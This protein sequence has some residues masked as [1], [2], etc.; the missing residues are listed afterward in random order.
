MDAMVSQLEKQEKT[1]ITRAPQSFVA[2]ANEFLRADFEQ[3]VVLK[4]RSFLCTTAREYV[5]VWNAA[6]RDDKG[7]E[8]LVST[9][10]SLVRTAPVAES[11]KPTT[12]GT[13]STQ[14]ASEVQEGPTSGQKRVQVASG[15]TAGLLIKKVAPVY[16]QE[17]RMAYIQ[18]TVVMQADISREGDIVNLEVTDGPIELAGSAVHAVRHW[19]YKP[20]MLNGEAVAVRTTIQVN[21]ALSRN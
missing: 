17:A 8:T 6:A 1:R 3:K 18:G 15:M 7:V 19:K 5:L 2:G 21:Y 16:P 13:V 14:P 10:N 12:P 9:L 4:H 11:A 20:Y